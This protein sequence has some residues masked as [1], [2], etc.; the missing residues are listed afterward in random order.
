MFSIIFLICLIPAVKKSEVC[1]FN[2]KLSN[3]VNVKFLPL[4]RFFDA[5]LRSLTPT[6][7][8]VAYYCSL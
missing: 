5:A 3:R 2:K 6:Q 7:L 1:R 8:T 4:L